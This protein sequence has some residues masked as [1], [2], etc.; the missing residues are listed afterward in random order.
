MTA[1]ILLCTVLAIL[2]VLSTT[3]GCWTA[4]YDSERV[5]FVKSFRGKNNGCINETSVSNASVTI[6]QLHECFNIT[7]S[8]TILFESGEF[9]LEGKIQL[10]GVHDVVL[11]G[12]P[13][14]SKIVCSTTA[15][16]GLEIVEAS[17]IKIVDLVFQHCGAAYNS[18][19]LM[20]TTAEE[21]VAIQSS[22][23]ISYST[24]ITIERVSVENSTG[25]AVTFIDTNGT[26]TIKNSQFK[27]STVPDLER[28][29]SSGGSGVY[30]EFTHHTAHYNT[31]S[32]YLFQ[33][34]KFVGNKVSGPVLTAHGYIPDLNFNSLNK[35]GGLCIFIRGQASNNNISIIDTKFQNNSAKWGGG[36]FLAFYD[37][38]QSNSVVVN[39]SDFYQNCVSQFSGGVSAGYTFFKEEPPVQNKIIF[40]NCNFIANEAKVGGGI[41]IYSAK[42]EDQKVLENHFEFYNCTWMSNRARYGS[43]I[44]VSP[45]RWDRL[46]NGLLPVPS[47]IDCQ[48]KS[49]EVIQYSNYSEPYVQYQTGK[50]AFL[51][52]EFY[53]HF[54]GKVYFENNNG[55]AIYLT[56]SILEFFQGTNAT[57]VD[58]S[59]SEGGAMAII[60]FSSVH[61]REYSTFLFKNNTAS[62]KGG[63]IFSFSIDKHDYM[64]AHSCFIQ[65]TGNDTVPVEERNI[66]FYFERNRAGDSKYTVTNVSQPSGHSIFATSLKPCFHACSKSKH[67]HKLSTLFSCIGNFTYEGNQYEIASDG[68]MFKMSNSTLPLKVI[69]GKEF[70]LP[71]SIE[72]DFNHTVRSVYHATIET[73]TH[74]C[75]KID[76]AYSYSYDRRIKI[77]GKPKEKGKLRLFK[78]GF[79]EFII[80]FTIELVECPPGFIIHTETKE[81]SHL[82]LT[83]CICATM[84]TEST[85][86]GL[87]K[88]SDTLFQAYIRLHYW[89]GYD[90]NETESLLASFCPKSFCLHKRGDILVQ[91]PGRASKKDLDVVICGSRRTGILCA[92]CREGYS[93]Y[94]HSYPSYKCGK[95]DRCRMGILYYILSELLPLTLL[96]LTVMLFNINFTSGAANGFI[97]FAQIV[98]SL[99]ITADDFIQLQKGHEI[100]TWAYHFL[101]SFFNFGFN[102]GSFCL[103]KEATILDVLAFKYVTVIY[104][105]I[106]VFVTIAV[107]NVCN[108]YRFC[109]CLRL[110][111]VKSSVVQGLSAFLIMCYTQCA[112][113]S[114]RILAPAYLSSQGNKYNRTVVYHHGETAYFSKDHLPYAI[115]AIFCLIVIVGLPTIVLLVYPAHYK[116]LALFR[117][118]ESR[119]IC[120][121][122]P[123]TK[124]KPLFDSFQSCYKDNCRF[125]AGLYFT[126]RFIIILGANLIRTYP[127]LYTAI[128]TMLLIMILFHALVQPYR[129]WWHNAVDTFLFTDLAIINGLSYYHYS[130][131]TDYLK[132]HS[133][134]SEKAVNVTLTIQIILIY[135]PMIYMA[136]YTLVRLSDHHLLPKIRLYFQQRKAKA[137]SEQELM[138]DNEFPARL[139]DNEF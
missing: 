1:A 113:V 9:F 64:S 129:K 67:S 18:T 52:S 87:V 104:A 77:F 117:W 86:Q 6:R 10:H 125:Y 133:I 93:T 116:C 28:N 21:Y 66:T 83:K 128:E 135:L 136:L 7:N 74:S 8:T 111:S 56:S 70:E 16:A 88:C 73:D 11:M 26:V 32:K 14:R 37:S 20:N 131:A 24:H 103:W 122:S 30:V 138:D 124:L 107:M 75:I 17:D 55:S 38:P 115:P 65:Y 3:L 112:L 79:R 51:A 45:H 46:S 94:Y 109:S 5:I 60:G 92:N 130:I 110:R 29:T 63:A 123:I 57:F 121:W 41:T 12:C 82:V 58:N 31:N 118:K 35:G 33:S 81:N 27:W 53:I 119:Q 108:C 71:V 95:N 84:E 137:E 68:K 72:D 78:R 19:T 61:V 132:M 101:Y 76:E 106:L 96:F 43:A 54:K 22:I 13:N 39:N 102:V 47:F 80:S 36:L 89:I 62:E 59:G 91:L 40:H 134:W 34:C 97:F 90:G 126:Y 23:Y 98:S 50:G 139:L 100:L 114:F 2:G 120:R 85:F 69:P 99:S 44:D 15:G 4:E 42:S 48:F 105:L 127:L 25:N 49:N